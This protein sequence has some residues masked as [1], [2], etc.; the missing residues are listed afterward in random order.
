MVDVAAAAAA[1]VKAARKAAEDR[2]VVAKSGPE[3]DVGLYVRQQLY[4]QRQ[5]TFD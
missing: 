3:L 1:V 5:A 2:K 4:I